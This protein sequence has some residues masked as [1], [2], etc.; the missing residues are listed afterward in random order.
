MGQL[1]HHWAGACVTPVPAKKKPALVSSIF[2][3]LIG[4]KKTNGAL[5]KTI[6]ILAVFATVAGVTTSL[7]LGVLQ[8]NSGLGYLFGIPSTLLVQIAIIAVITVSIHMVGGI[9]DREGNQTDIRCQ[10]SISH[11]CPPILAVL[12]GP[13]VEIMNNFCQRP[14]GAYSGQ[15]DSR[16]KPCHQ[17]LWG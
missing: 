3:P 8:I 17:N 16:T 2:E 15:S 13:K 6:D 11:L 1:C 4:E 5:G 9:R 7:G 14:W 10:A 12:V